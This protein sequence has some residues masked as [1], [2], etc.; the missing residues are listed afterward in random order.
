MTLV[1]READP[2]GV[3]LTRPQA[4][5]AQ[6][7]PATAA[8]APRSPDRPAAASGN[9]S[10]PGAPDFTGEAFWAGVRKPVEHATGMP[11]EAYVDDDFFAVEQ[12]RVFERGWV[13]V[14]L[15]PEVAEPGRVLVRRVGS[16]SVLVVRGHDGELRGFLNAC[17]HRGTE[18]AET[19]CTV[20]RIIRCPYHRWGYGLDGTLLATPMFNEVPR[21]GFDMAD[22]PL[23]PVRVQQWGILVFACC[24]P[25]TMP[26]QEWLGD[27]PE[28]M[29]DYHFERWSVTSDQT[30]DV[31]CNWKLI[32]ENFQEYYHLKW[33]HP[34]LA[35]VSRVQDHYR[36]QGPGLYCGQTTT[37]VT[38][39]E[40]DE[41]M[42]LPPAPGLGESDLTSG[43]FVAVYPNATLAVLPGQAFLMLLEPVAPGHT[44]ERCVLTLAPSETEAS[45]QVRDALLAFWNEI[46]GEDIWIMELAQRGL[47]G[48]NIPAGPLS[49]RFE[50]PLNRFHKIT[51][52]LISA[53]SLSSGA[54][55]VPT[56]DG[57]D[58]A[59]RYGTG[60][61]PSP[62]LIE[63]LS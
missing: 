9:G 43:R 32:S 28:R 53:E 25:N 57:P 14:G 52:D 23:M 13:V 41:W 10:A 39:D 45:Q 8:T 46:N 38:S 4:G 6:G 36:Y 59:A 51:A 61:N 19:D 21:P 63:T 18:L 50:E 7:E 30:L 29:A 24:D 16:K 60:A 26:L 40:R 20:D 49:P 12:Q 1:S 37:P 27:L 54:P 62:P 31:R 56:G 58:A 17:R 47:A 48:T 5:A 22:Y 15:V 55:V 42:S 35:K 2:A 11:P 3:G 33:V 44:R 34:E